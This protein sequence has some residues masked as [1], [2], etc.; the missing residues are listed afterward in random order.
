MV[1]GLAGTFN[2]GTHTGVAAKHK[3]KS[4]SQITGKHYLGNK[5][6][7]TKQ[8]KNESSEYSGTN[9]NGQSSSTV[10]MEQGNPN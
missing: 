1:R 2:V 5:A 3:G 9:S 8:K 4:I 6:I 7:Y 10:K